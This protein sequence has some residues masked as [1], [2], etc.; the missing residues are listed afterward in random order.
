MT[1]NAYKENAKV[2]FKQNYW[3]SVFAALMSGPIITSMFTVDSGAPKFVSGLLLLLY[4][5]F[6]LPLTVGAAS[7]FWKNADG[8]KPQAAEIFKP[9]R[10]DREGHD[11]WNIILTM[12]A[13]EGFTLICYFLLIIPGIIKTYEY[14]LV[15]YI[16][17]SDETVT[18]D[19]CLTL[20][21]SRWIMNGH[22]MDLFLLD[23][24]FF[25]W[26]LLDVLT[27]GI[28]GIFYVDPYRSQARAL[29]CKD[30][31]SEDTDGQ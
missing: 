3:P 13:K 16:L 6:I 5:F 11:V 4:V 30:L 26:Y 10:D 20:K 12:A 9:F 23:L 7:V 29:F 1:R 17:A 28:L 19:V 31:L 18:S 24:S 21:R 15:P 27:F 14:A 25:G 22:K 8:L 2:L